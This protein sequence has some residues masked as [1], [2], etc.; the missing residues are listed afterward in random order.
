METYSEPGEVLR[1]RSWLIGQRLPHHDPDTLALVA[2]RLEA[3]RKG[4]WFD[5]VLLLVLLVAFIVWVFWAGVAAE[6]GSLFTVAV[7]IVCA[8]AISLFRRSVLWQRR[9]RATAARLHGRVTSLERPTWAELLGRPTLILLGGLIA[10][11]LVTAALA[12]PLAA[13]EN[14]LGRVAL[15]VLGTLYCAALLGLA[16]RRSTVARDDVTL[17]ADRR[18]RAE[19]AAQA[20]GSA[21]W[22][23]AIVPNSGGVDVVGQMLFL[24]GYLL[25][26]Y[27]AWCHG[28]RLVRGHVLQPASGGAR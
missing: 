21:G 2:A 28:R 26:S 20:I 5:V 6:Y 1:A 10:A 11:A 16:R 18:L 4:R 15:V 13:A 22:F 24:G 17:I 25:V 23:I 19:E 14:R 8:M 7:P 3:R 9:E 27:A 12:T